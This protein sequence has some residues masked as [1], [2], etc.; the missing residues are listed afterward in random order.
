MIGTGMG[1]GEAARYVRV[2]LEVREMEVDVGVSLAVSE[3]EARVRE[4]AEHLLHIA[5][6]SV[7]RAE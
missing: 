2:V 3:G 5:V 1:H 6:D 4:V 7:E